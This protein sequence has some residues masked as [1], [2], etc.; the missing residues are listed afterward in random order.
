[1]T[2]CVYKLSTRLLDEHREAYEKVMQTFESL[3]RAYGLAQS[4]S[5]IL[6]KRD[7][8]PLFF[9]N[10]DPELV[11]NGTLVKADENNGRVIYTLAT[12][13][14]A[15][16]EAKRMLARIESEL[17]LQ[18]LELDAIDVFDLHNFVYGKL[19]F[20]PKFRMW[21]GMDSAGRPNAV[22]V[23]TSEPLP[24]DVIMRYE[25]VRVSDPDAVDA[26]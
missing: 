16:P 11:K 9:L 26:P 3:A 20:P 14:D 6:V 5:E 24:P 18:M 7:K 4:R 1:M 2:R 13:K 22:F 8:G 21:M 17:T 10:P 15:P 12:G 23:E 25:A 19:G